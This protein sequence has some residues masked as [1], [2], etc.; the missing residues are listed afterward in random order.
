MPK[1][2]NQCSHEPDQ[3]STKSQHGVGSSVEFKAA[4]RDRRKCTM[5]HRHEDAD[6]AAVPS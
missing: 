3:V 2:T 1:T 6:L 4:Q 5:E